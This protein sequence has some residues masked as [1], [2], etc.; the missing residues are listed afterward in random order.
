MTFA[1]DTILHDV[2]YIMMSKFEP[3]AKCHK[4]IYIQ[5]LLFKKVKI[6]FVMILCQGSRETRVTLKRLFSYHLIASLFLQN[7]YLSNLP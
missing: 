1:F 7:T 6:W 3:T 4:F 2:T 5:P